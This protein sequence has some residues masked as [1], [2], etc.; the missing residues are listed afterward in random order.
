MVDSNQSG[1]VEQLTVKAD[2]CYNLR[3]FEPH[4]RQLSDPWSCRQSAI[5][6]KFFFL[7]DRSAW[8][9]IHQP[10]LFRESLQDAQLSTLSHPMALHIRYIRSATHHWRE[11]LNYK[12]AELLFWVGQN[13]RPPAH[14]LMLTDKQDSKVSV[15]KPFNEFETDFSTT[16][17]IHSIRRKLHHTI[18]IL[19]GILD[20]LANLAAHAELVGE[21]MS[22]SLPARSV[23]RTELDQISS[24]MKSYKSVA[25][26]LLQL[27]DDIRFMVSHRVQAF[28]DPFHYENILTMPQ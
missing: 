3:Y 11:Y 8:V 19:D 12:N 21:L 9:V 22:L 7:E 13:C 20:V 18:S 1:F 2:I 10:L 23:L 25:Q 26:N 5:H 27:S 6:Q 15:P 17:N 4:G 28:S 16:Q 24:E 14:W